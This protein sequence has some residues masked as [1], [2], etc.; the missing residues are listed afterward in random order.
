MQNHCKVYHKHYNIAPG[1]FINCEACNSMP[2]VDL[3]HIIPRSKF[4]S[5]NKHEQDKIENI[6]ALCRQCHDL[7]H[8]EK[9]SKEYLQQM[10]K[11]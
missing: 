5:K 9:I 8:A 7:A 6:I 1:E 3:H 2:A 11:L 10:H 4:G